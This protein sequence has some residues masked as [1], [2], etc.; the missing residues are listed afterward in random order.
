MFKAPCGTMSRTPAVSSWVH[1]PVFI[2]NKFIILGKIT[3]LAAQYGER[4][5]KKI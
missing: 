1:A 5:I 3:A 4:N 2:E